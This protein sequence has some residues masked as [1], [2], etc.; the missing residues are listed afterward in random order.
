MLGICSAW[1]VGNLYFPLSGWKKVTGNAMGQG[2][3]EGTTVTNSRNPGLDCEWQRGGVEVR[4]LFSCR[5]WCLH[6][7]TLILCVFYGGLSSE[8]QLGSDADVVVAGP[9]MVTINHL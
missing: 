8:K 6:P 4:K 5:L 9:L 3:E 1:A 2:V 7:C